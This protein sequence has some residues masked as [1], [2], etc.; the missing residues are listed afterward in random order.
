MK[1]NMYLYENKFFLKNAKHIAGVDE[2]GRGCWAG[3]LVVAA[4]ILPTKYKNDHIRDSK[5]LSIKKRQQLFDVIIKDALDYQ[6]IFID[7]EEVDKLNPKEA[8]I[9]GM[10]RALT[11]LKVSPDVALIDFEKIPNLKIK[12]QSIVKGDA[13]SI[14]IAAASILAKVARDN[15]M[16]KINKKYPQYNFSK[17]KGYGTL[18]HV[19]EIKKYGPI[20]GFHRFS[21]KPIKNIINHV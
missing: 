14:S 8:S 7:P 19:K 21:Y 10:R 5:T 11:M 13:R 18:E 6:I 9:E 1:T 4:C 3:P 2:A 17:H 20:K 16:I 12:Q 15:Y